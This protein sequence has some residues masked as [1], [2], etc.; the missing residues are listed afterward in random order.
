M[1]R[2]LLVAVS[3]AI[4]AM[5]VGIVLTKCGCALPAADDPR[6]LGGISV[7]ILVGVLVLFLYIIH[8][9]DPNAQYQLKVSQ[10]RHYITYGKVVAAPGIGTPGPVTL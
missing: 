1:N 6:V 4:T 2:M 7:A 3:I 5:I 10:S 8:I 9:F